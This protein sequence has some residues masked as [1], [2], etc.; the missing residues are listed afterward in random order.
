MTEE[1]AHVVAIEGDE[2]ILES[3]IKS[4]CSSCSQVD[5]CANGQVAKALPSKKLT[6]RV[7]KSSFDIKV[8]DCIVLGISEGDMLVSAAQ[9]YLMPLLGL[10]GFSAIGQWLVDIYVLEHEL[11]ALVLGGLGGYLGY[12]LAKYR[13]SHSKKAQA[14]KPKILRVLPYSK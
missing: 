1:L 8:G 11:I 9:V 6:F 5:S 10:I 13:Q 2:V 7:K 14:L 12:K 4:T 3:Q